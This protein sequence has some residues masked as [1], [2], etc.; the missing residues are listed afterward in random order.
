MSKL[1]IISDEP[2]MSGIV[3]SAINAEIKRLEV[4]LEKT[5]REIRK[6]EE[7]YSLSSSEFL[8]GTT[9]DELQ[10]GDEDYIRWSGE[11]KIRERILEDLEKL[12]DIEYVAN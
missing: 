2:D 12:K 6:F 9:A 1:K 7:K 8:K 5:N 4:G 11:L 10:G 3:K